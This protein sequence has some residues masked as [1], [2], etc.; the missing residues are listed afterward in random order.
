MFNRQ[1]KWLN[2]MAQ[3]WNFFLR[4]GTS[5]MIYWDTTSCAGDWGID[6]EIK[7][8]KIIN[9]DTLYLP[10]VRV[11]GDP[12]PR[13]WWWWSLIWKAWYVPVSSQSR[14]GMSLPAHPITA[15]FLTDTFSC[16]GGQGTASGTFFSKGEKLRGVWL[17]QKGFLFVSLFFTGSTEL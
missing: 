11:E 14:W 10:S 9:L 15:S 2:C 13:I 8:H 3:I 7:Q 6:S 4:F 17:F 12:L 1:P 5:L 16:W